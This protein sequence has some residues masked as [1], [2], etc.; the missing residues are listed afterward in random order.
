MDASGDVRVATLLVSPGRLAVTGAPVQLRVRAAGRAWVPGQAIF[1]YVGQRFAVRLTG[2]GASGTAAVLP[3]SMG[4]GSVVVSGFQFPQNS[5]WAP[6]DG[7]AT[8]SLPVI[9]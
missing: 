9:G 3:A 1:I 5:P 2:P 4:T 6:V 8:V 7:A